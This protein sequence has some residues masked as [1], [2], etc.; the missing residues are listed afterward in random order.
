MTTWIEWVGRGRLVA[1]ALVV[2][3]V[4]AGAYWLVAPP[5]PPVESTLPYASTP[6]DAVPLTSV[7]V[8]STEVV[9]HVAGAVRVPGV[10]TLARGSRVVDAVDAAGGFALDARADAVNLATIVSDGERIY[11]PRWGEDV[12]VDP[13]APS[14][15]NTADVPQLVDLN[16]ATATELEQLPGIGPTTAAAI[17]AHRD[18]VGP[19]TTIDDLADVAGIGPAKLAALRDLVTV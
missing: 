13:V 10:Y 12:P 7:G 5:D 4:I 15:S 11:V 3:A 2:L 1:G 9:V 16:R 19:F 6:S 17:V 18:E 8:S 14:G